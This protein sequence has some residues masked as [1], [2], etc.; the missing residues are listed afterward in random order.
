MHTSYILSM[1]VLKRYACWCKR[2][3]CN[4]REY[5]TLKAPTSTLTHLI[6]KIQHKCVSLNFLFSSTGFADFSSASQGG[7]VTSTGEAEFAAFLKASNSS[8]SQEA[9]QAPQQDNFAGKGLTLPRIF[10]GC[11]ILT[12]KEKCFFCTVKP[13]ATNLDTLGR[14][15]LKRWTVHSKSHS[16]VYY[17][18]LKLATKDTQQTF[19]KD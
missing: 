8:S 16:S 18:Q 12:H 7:S 13:S 10:N 4:W 19:H 11:W 9:V 1:W 17:E 14:W 5:G 6:K 3:C 15:S 2:R